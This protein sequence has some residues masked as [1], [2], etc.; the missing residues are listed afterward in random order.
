MFTDIYILCTIYYLTCT[1]NL[2]ISTIPQR[3][4]SY[5]AAMFMRRMCTYTWIQVNAYLYNDIRCCCCCCCY[6]YYCCGL[7]LRFLLL[8]LLLSLPLLSLLLLL[9]LL[10]LLLLQCFSEF[11]RPS[12][13]FPA[14]FSRGEKKR[15]K[16]FL[17]H[18]SFALCCCCSISS[19]L[20]CCCCCCFCLNS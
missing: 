8:L 15:R 12:P 16:Q 17:L 7:V 3:S 10:P 14:S 18:T 2:L 19:L 9:L 13:S 1:R 4:S 20:C 6:Y 5:Y 11:K